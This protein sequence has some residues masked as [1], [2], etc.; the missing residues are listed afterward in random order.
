MLHTT[1]HHEPNHGLRDLAT[2]AAM[3][4]FVLLTC[5]TT[6]ALCRWAVEYILARSMAI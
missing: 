6:V 3:S 1:T 5:G 2:A 4:A